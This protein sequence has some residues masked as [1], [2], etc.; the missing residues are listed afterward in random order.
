M[1][2]ING[3]CM[4]KDKTSTTILVGAAVVAGAALIYSIPKTRVACGKLLG[5]VFDAFRLG[6]SNGK[7]HTE[8]NNWENDLANAEKLKGA[9]NKRKT[10]AIKVASAGTTAWK[11]D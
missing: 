1:A 6:A 9:V 4:L 5:K 2:M 8:G 10:P 3:G 11:E 7:S